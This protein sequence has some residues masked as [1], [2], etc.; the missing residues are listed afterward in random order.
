MII[1]GKCRIFLK[2]EFQNQIGGRKSRG[3]LAKIQQESPLS[4]LEC[5]RNFISKIGGKNLENHR[6]PPKGA[7]LG[8]GRKL[9]PLVQKCVLGWLPKR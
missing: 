9:F 1:S 3:G 7:F 5:L 8:G 4:P 2:N 6:D